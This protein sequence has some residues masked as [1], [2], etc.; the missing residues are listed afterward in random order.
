MLYTFKD[1]FGLDWQ[2]EFQ[3][4]NVADRAADAGGDITVSSTGAAVFAIEVTERPIDRARV[5]AT[6]NNKVLRHN[7]PD[8]MFFFTDTPPS[9]EARALARRYFGQGHD[10]NFLPVKQWLVDGLATIGTRHRPRFTEH[11]LEQLRGREMPASMKLAWNK[12]IRE[13][14]DS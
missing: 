6:F 1:A 13:L 9:P 2:I 10:M 7:L 14:L 8:Y 3:G 5:E 11:L 12:I 4:I